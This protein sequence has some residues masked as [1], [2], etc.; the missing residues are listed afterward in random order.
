MR[1]YFGLQAAGVLIE[2]SCLAGHPRLQRLFCWLV[3][4]GPAPLIVNE[5]VQRALWLWP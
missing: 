3:L 1:V 2:R 5:G 4:V